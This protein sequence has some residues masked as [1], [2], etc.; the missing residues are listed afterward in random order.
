MATKASQLATN[1]RAQEEDPPPLYSEVHRPTPEA[2]FNFPSSPSEEGEGGGEQ[3]EATPSTTRQFF[4]SYAEGDNKQHRRPIAI[5]QMNT[6]SSKESPLIDAYPPVLLQH[7]IAPDSWRPFL[8]AMSAFLSASVSRQALS[9]AREV[10]NHVA[11]V[12]QQFGRDTLGHV[13]SEGR[14]VQDS[15]RNGTVVGAIIGGVIRLP[16]HTTLRAVRTAL[17]DLPHALVDAIRQDPQ[18]PRERA[19]AYAVAANEKWLRG[20]GLR[21]DLMDTKQLASAVDL[22]VDRLLAL[23]RDVPATPDRQLKALNEYIGDL[24]VYSTGHLE[25]DAETLWLIVLEG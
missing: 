20:R 19:E 13:T 2:P 17:V 18:T 21:A 12:P 14:H 9:R 16:I 6:K 11:R 22:S 7:G 5:P 3:E 4:Q 23:V 15:A 24:E 8:R 1:P 25:L 10:A